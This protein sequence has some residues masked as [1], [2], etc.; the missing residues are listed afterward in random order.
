MKT[1]REIAEKHNLLQPNIDELEM[2]ILRYLECHFDGWRKS[3]TILKL[4][5]LEDLL[6]IGSERGFN[7]TAWENLLNE[8]I[9]CLKE[10]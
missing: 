5:M 10:I 1:A 8:K 2:D 6:K 7:G 9:K 4:K 3:E